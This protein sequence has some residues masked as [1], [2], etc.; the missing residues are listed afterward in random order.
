MSRT[1]LSNEYMR[2]AYEQKLGYK[3][4]KYVARTGMQVNFLP[5]DSL[6][7][8]FKIGTPVGACAK[9]E[10][11]SDRPSTTCKAFLAK[12]EKATAQWHHEKALAAFEKQVQTWRF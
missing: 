4:L 3:D 7:A 8:D 9:D 12:S 11:G 5:G 2:A 1:D 6:W 10:L